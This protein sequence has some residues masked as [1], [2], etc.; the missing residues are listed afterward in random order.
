MRTRAIGAVF[1]AASGAVALLAQTAAADTYPRQPG[2]DALHYVFNLAVSDT[3]DEVAGETT[4]TL[5]FTA[6]GVTQVFLDLVSPEAGK[7]MTVTSVADGARP[8]QHTHAAN[9]LAIR[10]ATAPAERD[11]LRV[12]VAYKGIPAAGLRALVNM[13]GDRTI[14]SHN[15]PDQARHWLPV[16]DHP[17]DKAAGEFVV[18]APAHYQVV[19]NGVLVEE[20]DLAG[21]RRRTHWKQPAPIATWLYAL[22]IARFATHHYAVVRGIPQ[23]V[24]VFPQ[25]RQSGYALFED[26][27]RRAFEYFSDWIGPYAYDKLAHVEAAGMTGGM[28]HATAIFYGEKGVSSG[29]GPVVH[30]VAHQWW[31]NAVTERD[32]DDVWLSE[33]FATYFTRLFTE[34]TQG[35]DA[36]VR[37][38]RADVAAIIQA[39]AEAPDQ[40]VIHRN[41]ADM[42]KV[43]NRL[44][45]EKGGWVLHMLR[46]LAGPERFQAGMREYY[47]RYRHA[48]AS[49]DDFRR[50]ME[51]AAGQELSWFFDQWLKRPGIPK[52]AGQWQYDAA[53]GRVT[54]AISQLQGG[55]PYRLPVQVGIVRSAGDMRLET[56]EISAADGRFSLNAGFEPQAVVLDPHTQV[57]MEASPLVRSSAGRHR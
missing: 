17:Y 3:S 21:G 2:V 32:W 18:T 13:H 24:W 38:L 47:R 55:T 36:F 44:V 4:V 34:H 48:N 50:I 26:T 45:Y 51:E 29:R 25:D 5:R 40:P 49:T 52:I 10:L 6:P 33:G 54:V 57:L 28:E 8:L 1:A 19:A 7:G 56:V 9:R 31:G 37:A 27:G 20:V 53:T 22:G 15:W 42:D 41:L 46:G 23:Q 35:R 16:I 43:L 11:E 12:T 30:E 14:F 39:Q